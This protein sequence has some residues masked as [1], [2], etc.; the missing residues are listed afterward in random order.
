MAAAPPEDQAASLPVF[1][2]LCGASRVLPLRVAAMFRVLV[3]HFNADT[4]MITFH[5]LILLPWCAISFHVNT[6]CFLDL[7]CLFLVY[8]T[9][10]D[11]NL[12]W[13]Y[14]PTCCLFSPFH[15]C[16]SHL[17]TR[18]VVKLALAYILSLAIQILNGKPHPG[19]G[20]KDDSIHKEV[21]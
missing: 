14:V 12:W 20:R 5:L 9:N 10:L 4:F 16:F 19:A 3:R 17:V 15:F 6:W 21:D 11:L 7:C 8:T 2:Q 18:N 13:I 1:P